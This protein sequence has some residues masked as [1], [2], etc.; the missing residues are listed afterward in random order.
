M[1]GVAT[2][3]MSSALGLRFLDRVFEP[4]LGIALLAWGVTLGGM[5]R[6]AIRRPPR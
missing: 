4:F 2:L 3:R 6:S 5:V 1:Y